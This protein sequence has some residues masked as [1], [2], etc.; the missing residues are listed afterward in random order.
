MTFCTKNKSD[1]P[2]TR[3]TKDSKDKIAS[4]KTASYKVNVIKVDSLIEYVQPENLH[5]LRYQTL[6][7]KYIPDNQFE[8]K[9]VPLDS[10]EMFIQ[11]ASI[12]HKRFR[13]P[14][15]NNY[16]GYIVKKLTQNYRNVYIEGYG[17]IKNS[18]AII[19]V[20]QNG[21]IEKKPLYKI[22]AYGDFVDIYFNEGY[23]LATQYGCCLSTNT[24]ELFN[25]QG[26]YI[27]SSNDNI[28]SVKTKNKQYFIGILKNEIPDTPVL[29]IKEVSGETQYI[30]FAPISFD[31]IHGQQFY[32][33]FKDQKT[34]YIPERSEILSEHIIESLNN[35][36]IWL[37]FNKKDTLKIPF[38][39]QKAF[40]IDYPQLKVE[41]VDAK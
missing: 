11:S 30:N 15:E 4:T 12:E 22:K 2:T 1:S 27:I 13:F 5:E 35:L 24:H 31:N 38:K 26:E 16:R 6:Y 10:G 23:F 28:K 14:E 41:L 29:F 8:T 3:Q 17:S 21:K 36:E 33:K 40:G 9:L 19:P 20:N 25:L 34:P 7:E 37:P 32:L 18:I 39:N